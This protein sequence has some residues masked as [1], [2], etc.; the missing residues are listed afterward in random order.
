MS[1]EK[2]R[3]MSILAHPD[4]LEVAA[5]G[6]FA[7]LRKAY[8]DD[9]AAK[10]L[11]TTRGASGH[12]EMTPEQ[13]SA[14]RMREARQ[15][16]AMIGAEYE[17]LRQLDGSRLTGQVFLDRNFMGGLWNAIRAFEP[18]VILSHPVIADPLAGVHVDHI[19]TA[20]AVRLVAYQIKVPHAYPTASG[21]VKQWVP[22]PLII[23]VDD[24]YARESD[25]HIRQDISETY[26][27]KLKMTR[28]HES[29][30]FEWLPFSEG[31]SRRPSDQEWQERFRKRHLDANARYGFHDQIMSEFFRIT[32]WGR[33]PRQGELERLFPRIIASNIP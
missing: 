1:P 15:S 23:N 21:A 19:N 14:R 10:I 13:T 33:A 27:V 12:H 9:V 11:T 16:A 6:S 31:R 4:D 32:R 25:F 2:L 30:F 29:Q 5:A 26:D 18:D 20:H 3:V 17:G 8:G 24:N 28:C 7:L 22:V